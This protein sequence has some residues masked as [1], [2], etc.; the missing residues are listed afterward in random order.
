MQFV[1]GGAL[2]FALYALVGG[3]E[4]SAPATETASVVDRTISI[5][6]AELRTLREAFAR[7]A[8]REPSPDELGDLVETFVHEE[9][10]YREGKALALDRD[11]V[12]VR[13]RI[14][15]KMTVL[16]RPAAPSPE[17][18]EAELRAW[19]A[20]YPHRFLQAARVSFEQR[21]F[22]PKR[23]ADA[24]GDARRVLAAL[25]ARDQ[26]RAAAL[27]AQDGFVLPDVM[28]ERSEMQIAHLYGPDFVRALGDAPLGR[29]SGPHRSSFGEHL[30]FV[31]ARAAG[32]AQPFA[33]MEKQV[34]ADWLTVS[35]RGIQAAG[36]T[37]LP[38]YKVKLD[39]VEP[40][41]AAALAKAPAV[42]PL[43]EG[44]R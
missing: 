25:G 30:V 14:I 5:G 38:R 23:R 28:E 19:F 42:A 20:R 22:D 13:R 15:E 3:S 24:A 44:A 2:I 6:P 12:I 21:F 18:T 4:E 7:S 26:G 27:P 31:K 37:L 35:T 41:Q 32:G 10:L 29:W 1:A 17:P 43:L 11:D 33:A 40:A 8:R 34:R 39:G 9:M 36:S 16:A